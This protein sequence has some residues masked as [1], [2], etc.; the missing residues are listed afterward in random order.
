MARTV[1][2]I[3]GIGPEST[4]IYYRLI[5]EEY[6]KRKT[7]G[8]YPLILINSI[9]LSN[10]LGLLMAANWQQL[11]DDLAREMDRLAKAGSDFAVLGANSAHIVFEELAQK[12]SIPLISI[13]EATCDHVKKIGVRT[14]GLFGARFTMQGGFYQ[15]VF[16]R[17]GINIA[18]PESQEQ[19]YIHDRYMNELVKGVVLQETRERLLAIAK[20]MKDEQGI[21]ALILGGTEL[22]LILGDYTGEDLL[23]L[24]TL[25][26]HVDRIVSDLLQ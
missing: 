5:I 15:K 23:I 10:M 17:E 11:I 20:R 13:V 8:T 24:D 4:L 3:G 21:Q 22:S 2:I 12:S 18:L 26:I 19:A 1:G 6:R 9:D 7:D 14:V 25:R 16:S